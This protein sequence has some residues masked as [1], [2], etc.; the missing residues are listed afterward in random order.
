MSGRDN[1]QKITSNK[2]WHNINKY[3]LQIFHAKICFCSSIDLV[4]SVVELIQLVFNQF[5]SFIILSF[6]SSL[7][8]ACTF[9]S[10]FMFFR[11]QYGECQQR[12]IMN[13]TINNPLGTNIDVSM[14]YNVSSQLYLKM[15]ALLCQQVVIYIVNI[16]F[17]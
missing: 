10:Y 2:E 17:H 7:S 6:S 16:N 11:L 8:P 3:D 15:F 14:A 9:S 5:V 4:N 13:E 12:S 1:F